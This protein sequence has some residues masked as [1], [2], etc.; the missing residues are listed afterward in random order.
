MTQLFSVRELTMIEMIAKA[1][2]MEGL[3][4]PK[5]ML[6]ALVSL[7]TFGAVAYVEIEI[8]F[9]VFE[10][11][12]DGEGGDEEYWSPHV[13]SL[14][15]LILIAAYHMLA[16]SHPNSLIVKFITGAVKVLIPIYLLGVG[17][18]IAGLLDPSALLDDTSIPKPGEVNIAAETTWF[19]SL[20]TLLTSKGASIFFS[21]GLGSLAI[22]NIF[23]SHELIVRIQRNFERAQ[24]LFTKASNARKDLKIVHQT[25][26]EYAKLGNDLADA[27]VMSDLQYQRMIIVNIVLQNLAKALEPHKTLLARFEI[28]GE[29]P[30]FAGAALSGDPKKIAKFIAKIEGITAEEIMA[31][32]NLETKETT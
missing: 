2:Y 3:K 10:A 8:I 7:I 9:R 29:Q 26:R 12:S 21:V 19:E 22:V 6:W 25:Q 15:A 11:L 1:L 18:F 30:A 24:E 4:A 5:Y 31:Y 16:E 23:V 14:S 13:M 20:F 17:L 28:D 27:S 32:L